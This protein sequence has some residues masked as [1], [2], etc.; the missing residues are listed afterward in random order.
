MASAKS[1]K[2][3]STDQLSIFPVTLRD[4]AMR[5][6]FGRMCR[7]V[8]RHNRPS[9]RAHHNST[10]QK[11][12][13]KHWRLCARQSDRVRLASW[14]RRGLP[15]ECSICIWEDVKH[16]IKPRDFENRA[17][18]F[19]QAGQ[20]ELTSVTLDVLHCSD[21][22]RQTRAVDVSHVRKIYH[23]ALRFFLDHCVE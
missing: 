11:A 7:G 8:N 19:L 13:S 2:T 20:Q 21:K 10:S 4:C 12:S 14:E 16:L 18:G 15:G 9:L 3:R 23:Q 17:H 22:G 1:L 6:S 5:S